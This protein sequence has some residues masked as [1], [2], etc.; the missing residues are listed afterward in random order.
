[1]DHQL[2]TCSSITLPPRTLAVVSVHVDLKENSTVHTY[3]VKPNGFL[4]D[5]Y[6][7]MVIIPVI[8]IMPMWTD[9]TFPFVIINLSTKPIFL[10]KHEV[11]GFL[12]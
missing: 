4:M 7:N 3:E 6:P 5:Q 9:T 1:M 2:V 10:A 11:L 12:D 8:H